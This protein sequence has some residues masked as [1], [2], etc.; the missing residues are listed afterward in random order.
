MGEKRKINRSGFTDAGMHTVTDMKLYRDGMRMDGQLPNEGDIILLNEVI[1]DCSPFRAPRG[2]RGCVRVEKVGKMLMVCTVIS[3]SS[4]SYTTTFHIKDFL[5]GLLVFQ[6]LDK[7]IFTAE[8]SY[9]EL[10]I[11]SV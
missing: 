6:T 3:H 10:R 7:P 5:K 11:K 4:F 9:E 2:F 8:H 1:R